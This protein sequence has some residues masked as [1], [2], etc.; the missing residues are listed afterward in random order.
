MCTPK[1]LKCCWAISW[2]LETVKSLL[3]VHE[4][5]VGAVMRDLRKKRSLFSTCPKIRHLS[6]SIFF[7]NIY[8]WLLRNTGGKSSSWHKNRLLRL[9]EQTSTWS[10]QSTQ[11]SFN[12]WSST[13]CGRRRLNKMWYSKGV[14]IS[15]E[16]DS[17]KYFRLFYWSIST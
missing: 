3:S 17:G 8:I 4:R 13:K 11:W 1:Y 2:I 12:I 5:A 14:W 10:L 16:V 15:G 7:L 6:Q 9:S